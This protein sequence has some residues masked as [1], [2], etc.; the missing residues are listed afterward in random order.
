MEH[1]NSRAIKGEQ[2]AQNDNKFSLGKGFH[3][4]RSSNGQTAY[5]VDAQ[6]HTC[7]CP[8]FTFNQQKCK[9]IYA[10]EIRQG[11][12]PNVVEMPPRSKYAQD[13]HNYNKSQCAEKSSFLNL[14][15]ELTRNISE[16]EIQSNGRPALPIGDMI[17]ACIFKVYSGMSARRFTTDLKDVHA[18]GLLSECPHYT[19]LNRYMEKAELTPYLEMLVEE[20]AKPLAS[21]ETDFA[22]DSTGLGVSNTVSWQHAKYKEPKMMTAKNWV[23]IHCCVGTRT[24]IIT[25][26]EVTDRFSHDATHFLPVL[27]STQK[28]FN[29]EQISADK[30]Y[31]SMKHH[32]YADM[33]GIKPFIAFRDNATAEGDYATSVWQK[34]FHYFNLN[35]A[36][37]LQHYNKRSNVETTFHMLKSKFGG[38]L[39]SKDFQAQKNEALAKVICHNI[40]VLTSAMNEFGITPE[41]VN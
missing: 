41:F 16:P 7:T 15:S 23:K 3:H 27:E 19:S 6:K 22:I 30:A 11:F 21:L 24:N 38:L 26:V 28:N 4:V 10:V 36:E 14:L 2:L 35:R 9:H 5:K 1:I 17:F 25:A 13:W 34:A 31:S 32:A 18:K 33:H 8:D 40:A 37:F 12:A 29:V 39:K 20:T